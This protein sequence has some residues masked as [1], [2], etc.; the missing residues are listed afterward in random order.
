MIEY[1]HTYIV[2]RRPP[3]YEWLRP[4]NDFIATTWPKQINVINRKKRKKN[5]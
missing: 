1:G 5:V 4:Y 3:G 2:F